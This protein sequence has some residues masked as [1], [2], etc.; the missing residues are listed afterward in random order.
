MIKRNKNNKQRFMQIKKQ[1]NK[2]KR[3]IKQE[4]SKRKISIELKPHHP[5]TQ[6]KINNNKTNSKQAKK[7][8]QN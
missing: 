7:K 1:T 6:Q 4:Q 2:N 3:V 8:L 5:H